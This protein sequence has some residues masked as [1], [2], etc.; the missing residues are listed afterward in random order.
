MA[1]IF[2]FIFFMP[3]RCSLF[4]VN[5][6]IYSRSVSRD[7]RLFRNNEWLHNTTKK[8][9]W[10]NNSE[11]NIISSCLPAYICLNAGNEN[12][13]SFR[14]RVE[15]EVAWRLKVFQRIEQHFSII[16]SFQ[17]L[18]IFTTKVFCGEYGKFTEYR[19]IFVVNL[20]SCYSMWW[21]QWKTVVVKYWKTVLVKT[22]EDC[23]GENS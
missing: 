15:I 4:V 18:F 1:E 13:C 12:V 10:K 8:M 6:I 19:T 14:K 9:K 2:N 7:S 21:K 11:I 20:Q 16:Y 3:S 5:F 22:V 17:W 23:C